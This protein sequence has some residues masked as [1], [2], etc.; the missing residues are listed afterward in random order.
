M[1]GYFDTHRHSE[2]STFDGFGKPEELAAYAKSI[3]Y[4]SLGLTDHGNTNGL[5]KHYYGCK[6]AGI[7]PILGVEAYMLPKYHTK[8][9]G[10]HLCLFAAN[11]EGYKNIN[12]M[13][14][15]GEM[16]K[17]YNPILD[18]GILDKHSEGVIATS[19]CVQGYLAKAIIAGKQKL[20]YKFADRMQQIFGDNFYI[21]IQPYKI[22]DKGTQEIVNVASMEIASK[23]GIKCILT[24]DSHRGALDDFD[25]Y[26]K[27]HEI[28]G[29]DLDH[30]ADTYLERY[31]PREKDICN[32]FV[33]MHQ[34]DL[35][36]L[37]KAVSAC[38]HMIKNLEEIEKKVDG[39]IF[40][41]FK[42]TLPTF[43]KG[44]TSAKLLEDHVKAGLKKRGKFTK[45][46]I[47]RAREELLT[48]FKLHF[49]DYFLMVEDY[50]KWA[51]S[52]GIV[53][54]PG[55]GSGCNFLINYAL[56]ITEVD[57]VYF[58]LEPRRFLMRERAKMPDIDLDFETGRRAEVIN[59]LLKRYAGKSARICSYGL[60]KVDNLVN[61]LAKVCGLASDQNTEE[62]I[63]REN[64]KEISYIKSAIKTYDDGEGNIN[65]DLLSKSEIAMK[66]NKRYDN[67]I[68][69]FCKLYKKVRYI[70]THSAGVAI[71][72]SN[73]LER[74]ALRVINGEVYT[75][76]D[77]ED[78]EDIGV[79]KFDMLGLSTM[80]EI[81]ECRRAFG[82][83]N[84]KEDMLS[85]PEVIQAFSDGNCDGIFQFEKPASQKML[86]DIHANCFNDV[87]AVNAMNRPGPLSMR[88]PEIYAKNKME[89][90]GEP[91]Y[92][93]QWL[94]STYGT[95]LYQEQVM[96]MC[97]D[98]AGMSW[99]D[100]YMVSKMQIGGL[101]YDRFMKNDFERLSKMFMDGCVNM[102]VPGDVAENTF[103][104]FMYYSF[105]QGHSV[106]YSLIT[107]EQMYYK[108]HDPI[109][110][111]YAKMRYEKNE[112]K[113]YKF[114]MC[115]A[116]DGVVIFLPHVNYSDVK[117][118][119]RKVDGEEILQ[120][121][122]S[123]IKNIGDG[124]A[125]AIATERKKH[126]VFI[127]Y[128]DFYDRMIFKGSAVNKRVVNA[129]L[130]TGALQ[131][132]K[133]MY[134]KAVTQYNTALI[135]RK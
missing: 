7:K 21:E 39:N 9:R 93:N 10:Y 132:N 86:R 75:S 119:V 55:R 96:R 134:I 92:F 48:V 116:K 59:Y 120:Q 63:A 16:Q 45:K 68:K 49:E 98:I 44:K 125:E 102:G 108:M 66:Y 69:H 46:Y 13:Q 127:S 118:I 42:E 109:T 77:L 70:G 40:D 36:S 52:N 6:K 105:N 43:E 117:T 89:N 90:T 106:G 53:V 8:H 74:T 113:Y 88:V 37:T 114:C 29:H 61:D 85:D 32:R 2:Y 19:A 15:M 130:N 95:I 76:Y 104:K 54:G 111:W 58:D 51:K 12:T 27:M 87:V 80:S 30:I 26:L 5:V 11:A 79:I 67:I 112:S 73:I 122:L 135:C 62:S 83:K 115:A 22:D 65:V 1:A 128:D 124:A 14:Y 24:S 82:I 107:I 97:V 20:A 103:K 72:D 101:N 25:T 133:K 31:M 131:F 126:G 50:V 78:M 81:G 84:F 17:Y 47:D 94:S 3:G 110:F 34:N 100:A 4:T 123:E 18:F 71:T 35:G 33:K 57:S 129:L 41:H 60:Y 121:G 38:E 56:G 99:D 28:A 64:A 91:S 23:L